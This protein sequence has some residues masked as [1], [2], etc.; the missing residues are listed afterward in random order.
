ML[1]TLDLKKIP[2]I[3]PI[4]NMAGLLDSTL[5]N[6]TNHEAQ[7]FTNII[8]VDDRSD[9]SIIKIV[10]KHKNIGYIRCDYD[11]G[12]N[13]SM[14]ANIAA[15]ICLNKGFKKIIY[16]NSD[17]TLP[18]KKV[19]P[20]LI[21]KHDLNQ[22]VISGT[23]LLYPNFDWQGNSLLE[24]DN[25]KFLQ[26]EIDLREKVQYGGSGV[27]ITPGGVHFFHS[28]RGA[29][30]KDFYVN[31]DKGVLVNTG[32]YCMMNL[33]WLKKIGGFNPSFAKIYND[34]DICLRACEDRQQV[35]YY[36][37]NTY[38]YHEESTNLNNSSEPKIDHQFNSDSILFSKIWNLNRYNQATGF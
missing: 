26:T 14:L 5:K 33:E 18:N 1:E 38:L 17:M 27:R 10:K 11:S 12:F 30:K 36:G 20:S 15:Y 31:V 3:L 37:K 24:S 13:Y 35:H 8:V 21:E 25:Y 6:L 32:A 4:R 7:K 23:K 22:P 29:D 28:K 16:W 2:L 9:D 34:I 19:L